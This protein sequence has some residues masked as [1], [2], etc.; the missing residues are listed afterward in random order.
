MKK[1]LL[2]L[3]LFLN[4]FILKSQNITT[5]ASGSINVTGNNQ[6]INVTNNYTYNGSINLLGN[7]NKLVIEDGVTLTVTANVYL[8]SSTNKINF[9]GCN[10]KLIVQGSYTGWFGGYEMNVYCN[11]ATNP[12]TTASAPAYADWIKVEPLP[13][14][15]ISFNVK[16]VD[17]KVLVSWVTASEINNDYF[18][19][20]TSS[21]G[22]NWDIVD[23]VEGM[24][25]TYETTSYSTLVSTTN[26]YFR[27]RQVDFNGNFEY[28]NVR[29][30][31]NS[32][33]YKGIVT[34][35]FPN[36]SNGDFMVKLN[37]QINE[38]LVINIFD[39]KGSLVHSK[40]TINNL[41]ADIISLNIKDK[42]SSGIYQITGVSNEVIF[43]E[44]LIIK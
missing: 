38:E 8:G 9:M 20:Q 24:G 44:K 39:M 31:K 18:E 35:I 23:I 21:N 40:I 4:V 25:N 1:L 7:D 43:S 3:T 32:N 29:Y 34:Q 15:L 22:I 5:F 28:S 17:A 42:L 41:N 12:L 14:E 16:S 27:L 36:P 30:I 2:I 10:A 13:V 11:T 33:S 26:T 37:S 19:V 6:S